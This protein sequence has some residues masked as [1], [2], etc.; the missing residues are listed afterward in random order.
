[1][2]TYSKDDKTW[3]PW[4]MPQFNQRQT[5]INQGKRSY[6]K[7]SKQHKEEK[8]DHLSATALQ[9][10]LNEIQIA[11][12]NALQQA[13]EQGV[14]QGQKKGFKMGLI[15]GKEQG[16]QKGFDKG[17]QEG[18]KKAENELKDKEAATIGRLSQLIHE[19]QTAL[20]ALDAQ[21]GEQLVALCVTLTKHILQQE[22][23]HEQYQLL[24]LIQRA[25]RHS[26][27]EQPITISLHPK[28]Y[29]VLKKH[30]EWKAHWQLQPNESIQPCGF[31]I[32][33]PWG[34]VDAQLETRWKTILEQLLPNFK[35]SN[36]SDLKQNPIQK[37][38]Q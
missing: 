1:M 14:K 24:P 5:P 18:L 36:T 29:A 9:K 17:Y 8:S 30:P 32:H 19:A 26:L 20:T 27:D 13:K 35:E 21:I 15:Q 2:S 3:Q 16:Y 37:N 6:T 25:L 33:A 7:S 12:E 11:K 31:K 34:Q 10:A 38:E 23:N 28:D 22:I 4:I